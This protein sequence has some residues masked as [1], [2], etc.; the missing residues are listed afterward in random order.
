VAPGALRIGIPI[1]G[2]VDC[3]INRA[4]GSRR[5][6]TAYAVPL[7]HYRIRHAER[8][9]VWAQILMLAPPN[10]QRRHIRRE[11]VRLLNSG[12]RNTCRLTG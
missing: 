10:V 9:A 5:G 2:A 7:R 11:A 3:E 6:V 1:T 4:P 8:I 12:Q